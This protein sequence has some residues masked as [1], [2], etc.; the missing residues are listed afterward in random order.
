MCCI[1][2]DDGVILVVLSINFVGLF[3]ERYVSVNVK[4]VILNKIGIKWI[5]LCIMYFFKLFLL[6][7][8][9]IF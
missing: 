7:F 6:F 9:F 1:S 5:N 2:L 8:L 3:G 4:N